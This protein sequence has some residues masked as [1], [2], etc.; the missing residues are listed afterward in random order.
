[1]KLLGTTFKCV[2]HEEQSMKWWIKAIYVFFILTALNLLDA[3]STHLALKAGN[4]E[5]NPI[6][7]FLLVHP[8]FLYGF[9]VFVPLLILMSVTH[10]IIEKADADRYALAFSLFFTYIIVN[11]F[12]WLWLRLFV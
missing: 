7:N 3:V 10:A 9:K 6:F 4:V 1:M 2:E 5:L 8:L 11:N 12:V